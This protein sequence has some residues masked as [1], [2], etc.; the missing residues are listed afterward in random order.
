MLKT[1]ILTSLILLPLIFFAIFFL[2]PFY[3]SVF[4]GLIILLSAWEWSI[5]IEFQINWLRLVYVALVL[6]GILFSAWLPIGLIL[7]IALF[8]WLWAGCAIIAYEKNKPSAGFQ[9]PVVRSLMGFF[10][11][12]A[13]WVSVIFLKSDAQLGPA[14]LVFILM[15]IMA[16]DVGAYFFGKRFG[17]IA[18]AARVSPNKTREGFIGGMIVAACV[19]FIG[20]FFFHLSLLQHVSLIMLAFLS[21]LFSALG[22]LTVSL[23]K[24]MS[25]IKDTGKIFPGHGGVLDRL[26]SVA[27]ATVV[28]ALGVLLLRL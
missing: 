19:A 24:R 14:W 12:I 3:F 23:L 6:F 27:A 4:A 25:G 10:I 1:R 15:I 16:A 26:D 8:F 20:G 22:D 5:F 7:L 9:F 18:L 2:P 17:K 13:C 28:F 11:L 21:A